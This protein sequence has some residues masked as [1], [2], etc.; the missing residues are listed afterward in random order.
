[1]EL[2]TTTLNPIN[3]TTHRIE[4]TPQKANPNNQ[5][6]EWFIENQC[7]GSENTKLDFQQHTFRDKDGLLR[8]M[9]S[10]L[11]APEDG[12]PYLMSGC[13]E[14]HL[15][16]STRS[17]SSESNV[18]AVEKEITV[19]V[20]LDWERLWCHLASD[21]GDELA[22]HDA[23]LRASI[24]FFMHKNTLYI[25][26]FL[27]VYDTIIVS[28]FNVVTGGLTLGGILIT[29]YYLIS[30]IFYVILY[31]LYVGNNSPQPLDGEHV[32]AKQARKWTSNR[33]HNKHW[34]GTL[35]HFVG[36][37]ASE[38]VELLS[39][40]SQVKTQTTLKP[41]KRT[42]SSFDHLMAI[43]LKYL[44]QHC[45]ISSREINLSR[46]SYKLAF[47][48]L[49]TGLAIFIIV[50]LYVDWSSV[51]SGC[52]SQ[53]QYCN[54]W[55]AQAVLR[56]GF[57]IGSLQTFILIGS[58]SI[59]I[60]GLSYGSELAY[61]MIGVWLKRFAVLR[62]VECRSVSAGVEGV[63]ASTV[64]RLEEG[65]PASD[66]G[67]AE[68]LQ[69]DAVEQYLFIAEYL[70]QSGTVWSPVIVAM[71][72]YG[73]LLF[74]VL[75]FTFFTT[76]TMELLSTAKSIS[77]VVLLVFQIVLFLVFPS[78]SLASAN[79]FLAPVL[80]VFTNSSK[81]DFNIIGAG[82]SSY[83]L[84]KISSFILINYIVY[85]LGDRWSRFVVGFC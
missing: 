56:G 64:E 2:T 15:P 76:P 53:P 62:R 80:D 18:E 83:L 50:Q 70:R 78:W 54:L 7:I 35:H 81:D 3:K 51:S 27:F 20:L 34:S 13:H 24:N 5:L 75:N 45:E 26:W 41:I 66:A 73:A 55:I 6:V 68:Y 21:K 11:P 57:I 25:Y 36:L 79:A 29:L 4:H 22:M 39:C 42:V 19:K 59:G 14:L 77:V 28:A 10:W 85:V 49:F 46:R 67:I 82:F 12:Y 52:Y 31:C 17:V 74:I 44:T 1:M 63:P 30:G 43:S 61:Y 72:C 9:D 60:I 69:R 84:Q 71:Y 38:G 40:K 16:R 33:P 48:G 65:A 23:L 58:M 47:I 8:Y 32:P 37:I